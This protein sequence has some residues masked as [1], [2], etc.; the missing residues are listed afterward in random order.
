MNN[1]K[2]LLIWYKEWK[3]KYFNLII[4]LNVKIKLKVFVI[5]AKQGQRRPPIS[6]VYWFQSFLFCQLVIY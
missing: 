1:N 3:K 5:L 4:L 6:F 2:K